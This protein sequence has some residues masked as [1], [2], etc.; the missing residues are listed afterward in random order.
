MR[1]LISGGPPESQPTRA[2]IV[3]ELS[4]LPKSAENGHLVI[5]WAGEV[6]CVDGQAYLLPQD[7]TADPKATG[8]TLEEISKAVAES[9]LN[10]QSPR[11]VVDVSRAASHPQSQDFVQCL[12][13]HAGGWQVEQ[14]PESWLR[15]VREHNPIK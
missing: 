14:S 2:N 5:F 3:R 15:S 4:Q 11:L 6:V 13:A 12:I 7:A 10:F 9:K 8:L 1:A